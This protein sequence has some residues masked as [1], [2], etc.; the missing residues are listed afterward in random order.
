MVPPN[1]GSDR[2]KVNQRLQAVYGASEGQEQI[3][4]RVERVMQEVKQ[5]VEQCDQD[6]ARKE[7]ALDAEL[8]R[9]LRDIHRSS[10]P[11]AECQERLD[12]V[13]RPVDYAKYEYDRKQILENSTGGQ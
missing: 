1:P 11:V 7:E 5:L 6:A 10:I 4:Q 3:S 13:T 2:F 9:I 12:L 8:Q